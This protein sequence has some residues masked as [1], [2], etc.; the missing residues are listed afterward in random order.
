MAQRGFPPTYPGFPRLVLLA[1][2]LVVTTLLVSA[3]A[4]AAADGSLRSPVRLAYGGGSNLLVS[5]H[6]GQCIAVMHSE[7]LRVKGLIPIGGRPLGVAWTG[8]KFVVGN[9]TTQSVEVYGRSGKLLYILGNAGGVKQPLDIEVDSENNQVFV[10]DGFEKNVKIFEIGGN[11]LGAIGDGLLVNPTGLTLDEGQG[12]IY[13][14]DYGD[15]YASYPARVWVLDYN[16][17]LLLEMPGSSGGFSR[18][19]GADL[20]GSGRLYLADAFLGQVLV[21]DAMSG[22]KLGELGEFGPGPGQLQLPLDVVY[23]VETSSIFVTNNRQG[24]IEVFQTGGEAP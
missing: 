4:W 7:T 19:Q 3:P 17:N 6:L 8:G 24:R 18:P 9:E 15:F 22:Q 21:L 11:F 14:S 23:S 2:T 16:G 13:V 5:D 12:R 20:D 1:V 10:V